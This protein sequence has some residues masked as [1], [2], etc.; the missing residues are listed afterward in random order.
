MFIPIGDHPNARDVPV[1]TW[2]L[3]AANVGV[4]LLI[5]WPLSMQPAD[6][7]DPATLEYLRLL[8][9]SVGGS[10]EHLLSQL[11]AYDIF[12]YT[13]G[14]R[15]IA[16]SLQTLFTSMF[17][18]AGLAHLFG[19]MLFLWIYG[20]N[21]EHRLGRLG[22]LLAYLGTGACATWTYSIFSQDPWIPVVG[23]SGAISGVLGC[24]FVWFP[25]NVVRVFVA[26]FP[27]YV[28]VVH[29]PARWVLGFYILVD[30]L[31]PFL[32][33][34]S[35][36]G[37]AYGAHIGGFVGGVALAVLFGAPG[38]P[39]KGPNQPPSGAH[40]PEVAHLG[41]RE[42]A[43]AYRRYISQHP[44]SSELA[45]AHLRLGLLHLQHGQPTTAYQYL[46]SALELSPSPEVERQARAALS[47]IAEL[48]RRRRHL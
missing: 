44:N 1:V 20:D 39:R 23:A 25:R 42:A 32:L 6:P 45:E 17:L 29:L 36:T 11:S 46:L 41:P 9:R 31:L 21:I 24:Y 27:F 30:N 26:L 35:S 22:Y 10:P 37:V 34:S 14:Y 19:N 8:Y 2:L 43:G 48:Q 40:L 28:D 13:H 7:R 5:S 12:I 33:Q 47:A 18:H 16:S 38:R 3:I 15:P 4:Y